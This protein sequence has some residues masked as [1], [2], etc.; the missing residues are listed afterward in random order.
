MEYRPV[1]QTWKMVR[2]QYT[3]TANDP[4]DITPDETKTRHRLQQLRI[5]KRISISSLAEVIKCDVETL[6][7]YERGDEV[8]HNETLKQLERHLSH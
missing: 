1:Y 5:A 4:K 7:A 3:D 2:P 8:L 6:A